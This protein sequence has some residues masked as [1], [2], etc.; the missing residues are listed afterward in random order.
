MFSKIPPLL[1]NPSYTCYK[2]YNYILVLQILKSLGLYLNPTGSILI[3]RAVRL[4]L[5]LLEALGFYSNPTTEAVYL[6]PTV[7]SRII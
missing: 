5:I 1:L 4:D 6:N 2:F 3:L 7:S